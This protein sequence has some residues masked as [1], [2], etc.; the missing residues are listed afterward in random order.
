MRAAIHDKKGR[1]SPAPPRTA[2]HRL[3]GRKL[4]AGIAIMAVVGLAYVPAMRAGFIW[5]DNTFLT[6]NALI[7][8]PD[9]LLRFWFSTEAPDYF[10]LTSSM[11]WIEW[12]LWGTNPA[13]Y[14]VINVLLHAI[15][16]VLVW[17]VLKKLNIPGAWLAGLIFGIHP[18][19]VESVA[20]I[21]ERKNTLP[22]VFYLASILIYLHAET[23]PHKGWYILALVAFLLGLLSKTSVVMLP[24]VLLILAWWQRGRIVRRDMLR[25][26]PFFGLAVVFG[27]V[28]RWFQY[29]R[30]ILDEVVREDGFASRLAGAGWAVWFYLGKALVPYKLTFVYPRWEID[31]T[32]PLSYVP[33]VVLC[34][35]FLLFWHYRRQWGRPMLAGLGYYVVTLLPILGFMNIYFMRYSL[36]ADHWQYTSIIGAVALAVG[37]I[38]ASV[39]RRPRTLLLP[40]RIAGGMV[41]MALAFLTWQQC[42]IYTNMETLWRDTIRKNPSAWMA[43]NNLGLWLD[44]QGRYAEAIEFYNRALKLRPDL[45]QHH[46]N[47]GKAY[48]SK[49][50]YVQAIADYNRAIELDPTYSDAYN[51]RGMAYG[52]L[53]DADREMQDYT[54]ALQTRPTNAEAYNNRGSAYQKLNDF[55]NAV[56]D[57]S[58]AIE[59]SP[60]YALAFRNRGNAY[61]GLGDLPRAMEDYTRAIDLGYFPAYGNRAAI[62]F[63]L[64]QYDQAWADVRQCQRHGG[65]VKPE[66]LHALT[67]VSNRA[68]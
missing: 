11:L 23:R 48:G 25:T 13:G 42:H 33:M 47:R 1:S 41:V 55:A 39:N 16:A 24:V 67:E 6:E 46:Y 7:K 32:S 65:T 54:Q 53:G 27:L 44:E 34:A 4:L 57:L 38:A 58:K 12:R 64:Q 59:L 56:R 31:P 19:N 15:S 36:V 30:A 10:P 21:T 5:D 45:A 14:H 37:L 61:A 35:C 18:V 8:A 20:W 17:L 68:R 60:K 50:E 3:P 29:H 62:F 52:A 26:I 49:E 66:L 22:M 2:T 28:T 63:V 43:H 40:A 9:G 51:N